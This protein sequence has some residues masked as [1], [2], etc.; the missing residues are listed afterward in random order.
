MPYPAVVPVGD[1]TERLLQSLLLADITMHAPGIHRLPALPGVFLTTWRPSA[2]RLGCLFLASKLRSPHAVHQ[3]RAAAPTTHIVLWMQRSQACLRVGGE[4]LALLE[5]VV[6]GVLHDPGVRDG[7]DQLP[8]PGAAGDI[9]AGAQGPLHV[10]GLPR[11]VGSRQGRGS[12]AGLHG[13]LNGRAGGVRQ[14]GGPRGGEGRG[15]R[16]GGEE[17]GGPGGGGG[18]ARAAVGLGLGWRRG[19]AGW[20][21][22]GGAAAALEPG[23]GPQPPQ[24]PPVGGGVRAPPAAPPAPA[25]APAPAPPRT[26]PAPVLGCAASTR[27]PPTLDAP[28]EAGLGRR[29][30][31]PLRS[32]RRVHTGLRPST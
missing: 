3:H 16:R 13:A 20:G 2:L 29:P 21:G 9:P 1:L 15:L 23:R 24:Q 14:R 22:G 17:A 7:V 32:T 27:A 31:P 25:P 19:G 5:V 6:T 30:G 4:G 26:R 12:G 10:P 18:G 8:L 28:R 11:P